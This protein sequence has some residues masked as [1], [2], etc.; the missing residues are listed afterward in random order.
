MTTHIPAPEATEPTAGGS[1]GPVPR[2]VTDAVLAGRAICS[3]EYL[4]GLILAAQLDTVGTP[5]KLARDLFPGVDP[6]VVQRIWDRAL[7]V[8]VRAG[9]LMGSPRFNRDKLARLRGELLEA[10]HHAMGP[11]LGR[12]LSV[13]ERAPEWHPEDEEIGRER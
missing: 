8:G 2:A 13:A 12:V 3:G 11:M 5:R 7:V 6:V 10:G 1:D 4:A 9:Q